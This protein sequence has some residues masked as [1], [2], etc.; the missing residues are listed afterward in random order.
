MTSPVIYVAGPMTNY[1]EFN[2]PAFDAAADALLYRGYA[3]VAPNRLT[4]PCGCSGPTRCGPIA[5]TWHEYMRMCIRALMDCSAVATLEGWESSRGAAAE[6]RIARDLEMRVA[7][8]SWW[9]E[10]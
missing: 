7:P 3:V 4:L 5:H 9:L 8:V 2:F 10:G 1:P 6:V